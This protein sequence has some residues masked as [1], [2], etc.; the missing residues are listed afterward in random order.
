MTCCCPFPGHISSYHPL[1]WVRLCCLHLLHPQQ[2][3][4]FQHFL[5]VTSCHLHW[6]RCEYK[7][8]NRSTDDAISIS[9]HTAL[10]H[11]VKRSTYVRMLFIDYS[12]SNTIVPSHLIIKLRT[13]GLNTSPCNWVLDI[14]TVRPLVVRVGNNTTTML[15]LNT[16]PPGVRAESPPILSVHPRLDGHKRLPAPSL[17]LQ[18][19]QRW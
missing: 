12:T 19:T 7:C 1:H 9:L 10:S 6:H 13:L 11:L 14:L 15:T 4:Q 8:P 5:A 17:S 2:Q 16:G 3:L 18:T